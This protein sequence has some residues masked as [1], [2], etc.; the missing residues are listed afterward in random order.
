M[1]SQKRL[2]SFDLEFKLKVAQ[3]AKEHS[4]AAAALEFGVD[5]KCVRRWKQS[6]NAIGE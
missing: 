6:E 2:R 3:Y 1:P 5:R 4:I